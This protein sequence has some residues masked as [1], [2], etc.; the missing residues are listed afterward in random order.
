MKKNRQ[1]LIL[2][3]PIISLALLVFFRESILIFNDLE[4]GAVVPWRQIVDFIRPFY[5]YIFVF[6]IVYTYI[7]TAMNFTRNSS[8]EK[9]WN[10]A[11]LPTCFTVSLVAFVVLISNE[12]FV[13]T[14]FLLNT[15]FIYLY[16]RTIYGIIN[17][18]DEEPGYSLENLSSYG[19]FL[20]VYFL[21]ASVYGLQSFL[22]AS[23]A[24]LM[25]FFVIFIAFVSYQVMWANKI[26]PK[27]FLKFLFLI[28]VVLLELAWSISFLT[29]SYYVLGL[30][31]AIFYY[32]LIGIIRFHLRGNLD[33]KIIKLYVIFGSICMLVVLLT[34]TWL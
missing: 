18:S 7:L 15:L 14:L 5:A 9:W 1:I 3:T 2:L 32:I 24:Y 26:N 33:K 29:L 16:F 30:V 4:N 17:A 22:G 23:I 13:G 31:L 28:C 11:I 19:N 21:S 20:A 27:E 10:Y 8:T 34:A 6:L 12:F 25:I